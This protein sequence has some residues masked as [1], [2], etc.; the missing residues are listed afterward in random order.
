MLNNSVAA[1][2]PLCKRSFISG[3]PRGEGGREHA[4][5]S[6]QWFC[7]PKT[8]QNSKIYWCSETW[9]GFIWRGCRSARVLTWRLR[10]RG[11]EP[12]GQRHPHLPPTPTVS[13][14]RSR[15]VCSCSE[16]HRRRARGLQLRGHRARQ[17]HGD[18]L[19]VTTKQCGNETRNRGVIEFRSVYM[20]CATRHSPGGLLRALLR[21]DRVT[22]GWRESMRVC[23]GGRGAAGG[24][25]P[26]RVSGPG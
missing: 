21:P 11:S 7:K 15:C 22:G 19:R 20:K 2:S 9:T 12:G 4:A 14:G 25:Q 3:R 8:S 1:L 24:G 18:R 6:P 16:R 13:G 10:P 23:E 5:R 17:R 26:R